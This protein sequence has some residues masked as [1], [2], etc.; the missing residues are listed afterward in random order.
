MI[1]SV[2]LSY[3]ETSDLVGMGEVMWKGTKARFEGYFL[4]S[5]D[6][7]NIGIHHGAGSHVVVGWCV[8]YICILVCF[9]K[10]TSHVLL[11]LLHFYEDHIGTLLQATVC[12]GFAS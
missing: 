1:S 4:F 11:H 5:V 9:G 6:A 8:L 10:Q 12:N 3:A 2:L 7:S